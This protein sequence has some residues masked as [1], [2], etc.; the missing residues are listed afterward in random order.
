M[1]LWL[2]RDTLTAGRETIE[3]HTANTKLLE[4][5]GQVD[6]SDR[7]KGIVISPFSNMC[8]QLSSLVIVQ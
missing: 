6:V 4:Q 7:C 5:E 1:S 2:P 3:R 8:L